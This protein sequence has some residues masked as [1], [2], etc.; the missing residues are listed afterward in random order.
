MAEPTARNPASTT[1]I[2]ASIVINRQVNRISTEII[3]KSTEIGEHVP[4]KDFVASRGLTS[5]E[6][7]ELLKK[8]GRNEL[9]EKSTPTWLVIFRLVLNFTFVQFGFACR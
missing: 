9:V 4:N 3:R 2:Q 6:A 5:D 8:W 1:E 7:N